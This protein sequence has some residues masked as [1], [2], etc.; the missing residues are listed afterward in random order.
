MPD[1]ATVV[2]TAGVAPVGLVRRLLGGFRLAYLPVLLTYFCYGA[3]GITGVALVFFEKDALRLT[4]AEVAGIGFWL[5]LPWS[6]KMVVGVASDVYPIFGS[7]R[8]AYLLLGALCSLAGYAAL[9][10]VVDAK[11]AFLV[12]MLVVTVGF[13]MQDVVADALSVE[14]A[15]NDEEIGQIQALGRMALLAGSISVGY[16]GGWLAGRIGARS[17]FAVAMV[18]PLLVS[19][20]AAFVRGGRR[21]RPAAAGDPLGGGKARL[22]MAVGLGYA[23]LGVV[24]ES[25]EVPGA[26]EIVLVVSAALIGLL[27]HQVGISRWVIV[28]ACVIFLFRAVPGVG[29]GYSYWAIDRLGFDQQFLG[30]LAQVSSVV[31]LAGLLVFRRTIIRRPVSFTLLWVTVAGTVLYLPSISLFYG[32]NEW[33][34]ISAR[35]FAFIDTTI[36]APLG[37]LAMVPMLVLIAKTAPP[38]AEATMFAIMASL[39]NLALSASELFTRHLNTAFAVTQQDYSNLG[40]LMITVGAI[41]LLPLLALPLLTRQ[42]RGG[43]AGRGSSPGR[44]AEAESPS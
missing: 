13:M 20:A 28:A 31:S 26:Q 9:A 19:A 22:V 30:I 23:A 33:L 43:Q 8:A 32:A 17:V 39:M 7:R 6:M 27:L 41:G 16:L 21:P 5:G 37:Q 25:L 18:L 24:L 40:Q 12:A 14:V 3:S 4:P 42:E 29:Q 36:S 2:P 34:G 35:T 44:A 10:T 1:H 38:G 11:G 15:G